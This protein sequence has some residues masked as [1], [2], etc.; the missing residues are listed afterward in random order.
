MVI[1][2]YFSVGWEDLFKIY[3]LNAD[4]STQ[5]YLPKTNM[6]LHTYA[7]LKIINKYKLKFKSKS[8]ISLGLQKSISMKNN[9]LK[10]FINK[11]DPI[12]KE[13]FQA[14]Y[15]ICRNLRSTLIKKSKQD[16]L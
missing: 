16:Y 6:V 5:I 7:P 15:K 12:L 2:D 4:K 9:L 10:S 8:W 13:Q 1:L 3:E 14:N 11:S